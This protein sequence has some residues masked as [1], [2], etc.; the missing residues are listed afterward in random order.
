MDHFFC[1]N[2]QA[3]ARQVSLHIILHSSLEDG[4]VGLMHMVHCPVVMK[5][6]LRLHDRP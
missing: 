2:N 3:Q 5:S 4:P 1:I 6:D